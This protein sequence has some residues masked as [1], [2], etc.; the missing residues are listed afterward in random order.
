[1]SDPDILQEKSGVKKTY[2]AVQSSSKKVHGA[3]LHPGRD[4]GWGR[5][6]GCWCEI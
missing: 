1:M 4:S 2:Q 5:A 3:Q 6:G